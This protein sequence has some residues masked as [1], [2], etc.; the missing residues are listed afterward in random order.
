VN[1]NEEKMSKSLGNFFTLREVYGKFH[2]EVLRMFILGTHY[3]S[4]LDFSDTA[5][6]T[7][8]AG[9]DR[10]Y[11]T[12]KRIPPDSTAEDALPKAFITAMNDD[13]NTAE[14]LAVLFETA[15]SINRRVD[16]EEDVGEDAAMFLAM[17]GLLGIVQQ[18]A[19]EWFKFGD[20][21]TEKVE[22]LIA[23]REQ[24]RKDRDFTRADA[25]RDELVSEGVMLEDGAKG[26]QWK[27]I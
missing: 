26:T 21:D 12:R 22:K 4:P 10:L 6:E 7:A 1:I 24:A 19:E 27:K 3:R 18:D 23:E 25:I 16:A 5:L 9:L 11:E 15:R 17:C 2:P 8:K 20:M 14:A 13:F